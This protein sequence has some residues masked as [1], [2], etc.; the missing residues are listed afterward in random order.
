MPTI[1]TRRHRLKLFDAATRHTLSGAFDMRVISARL[2]KSEIF[3]LSNPNAMALIKVKT[4]Y[5]VTLPTSVRKS[6]GLSV[7]DL[8]EAK[9][10]GNK[11]TLSPKTAIDKELALSLEDVKA[12]RVEGPFRSVDAMLKGL[13]Q[14]VKK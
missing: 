8:L 1:I 2:G 5:Q 13:H 11:I 12:G 3:L 9:V 6:V 4:K 14:P 7:G 10:E